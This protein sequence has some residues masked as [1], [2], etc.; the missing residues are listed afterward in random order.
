MSLATSPSDRDVVYALDPYVEESDAPVQVLDLATERWSAL[1][2]SPH[3][4]ALNQRSLVT[5]PDGLVVMGED[6]YPREA[7]RHEVEDVHA[8]IW[9]GRSWTRFGDSEV[10]GC[11]WHWTGE[12]IIATYRYDRKSGALDPATGDWSRLPPLPAGRQR[13]LL[14]AGWS[15]ADGQLVFGNGY[16]Y[17]DETR[18]SSPV[19]VPDRRISG[20]ALSLGDGRLVMFGGYRA[21][22]GGGGFGLTEVEPTNEAWMYVAPGDGG[23]D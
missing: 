13:K 4:P 5:T 9:D 18:A 10:R 15:E 8:E 22:S 23:S 16:L 1:A 11:C 12:R 7:G 17:D 6:Y 19:P 20:G 3:S 2:R 14:D 21:P